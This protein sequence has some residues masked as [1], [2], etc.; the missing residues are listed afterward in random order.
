[1]GGPV[2]F[3][4]NWPRFLPEATVIREIAA[5]A[6]GYVTA[7]DGEALGMAV[8]DLGGGR[9]VEGEALNLAVGLSDVVRIG[10]QVTRG[11]PL[12]VVH[13]GRASD[14][15]QAETALR[16]AITIAAAPVAAPDLILDRVG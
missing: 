16:A 8:V 3:I 10:T 12:A 11:Q 1:M 15:D 6:S 7:I 14:A 2:Q 9:K 13:A 4:E 5:P